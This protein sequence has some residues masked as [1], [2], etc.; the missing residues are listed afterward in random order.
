MSMYLIMAPFVKI[1][2]SPLSRPASM[3]KPVPATQKKE[4][5]R[6]RVGLCVAILSVITGWEGGRS[7]EQGSGSDPPYEWQN[8][9]ICIKLLWKTSPKSCDVPIKW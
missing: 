4:R 5:L 7:H 2:S 9:H 3:G 1:S 6:E 8:N